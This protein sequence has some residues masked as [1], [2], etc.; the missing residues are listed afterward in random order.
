MIFIDEPV[1]VEH[2]DY[3]S[4][5]DSVVKTLSKNDDV[6]S[7]YQVGG[8][9][10][11][12]ISDIDIV[13]IFKDGVE[14]QKNIRD[15]LLFPGSYLFSHN[16]LGAPISLF[17]ASNNYVFFHNSTLLYGK[18]LFPEYNNSILSNN[19]DML[20]QLAKEYLTR[21][22]ISATVE[23]EFGICKVRSLLLQGKAL[24]YD[25]EFL[26]V[27]PQ[28]LVEC[29]NQII[30]WREVWFSNR[31]DNFELQQF[32]NKFW[33][34]LSDFI[35]EYFIS[36]PLNLPERSRFF[37]SHNIELRHGELVNGTSSGPKLPWVPKSFAR[38]LIAVQHRLN[39]IT[40]TV[41]IQTLGVPIVVKKSFEYTSE[42][43]E[44]NRKYLPHFMPLTSSLVL[45]S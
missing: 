37:V 23:R 20:R 4:T 16:L 18:D 28:Q 7:V 25:L 22:F 35:G 44:Y 39:K 32:H 11:P 31:P 6:L 43:V 2:A 21:M 42:A 30:D 13:V 29:V 8:V 34:A 36:A 41:P 9:T 1:N 3:L 12:G 5:I 14:Y 45:K 10:A 33:K 40:V 26:N 38:K 24:L 27:E 15:E 19:G 17:R